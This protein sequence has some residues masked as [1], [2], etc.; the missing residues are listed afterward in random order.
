[1]DENIGVDVIKGIAQ[2]CTMAKCALVGGE[3]AE[4]PSFYPEVSTIWLASAL[5]LLKRRAS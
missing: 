4:M 1:L 5:V 3:T 2:G